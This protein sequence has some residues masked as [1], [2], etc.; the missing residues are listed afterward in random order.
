MEL[1]PDRSGVSHSAR[2]ASYGEISTALA[3]I[4]DRQLTR[5]VQDAPLIG[6]GIGGRAVLVHVRNTPVFVKRVP[7]TDLERRPENVMSTANIFGLPTFYHYGV[8]SAGSGAWRE[9]AA[10]VMT[11]NWVIGKQCE[12]F[13][14]MYHWRVLA[15]PPQRPPTPEEQA[16]LA[17]RV[18]YWH[19]SSAV[20]RRLEEIARSS[21][22][23]VLFCEYI[24]QNLYEW[25]NAQAARGD[26]AVELACAMVE[27]ALRTG[28]SF[29]NSNGLLH[30]DAHL[31]NI[32]TDGRRLYFTD[33]GLATS[34]RFELSAAESDFCEKNMSHDGCYTVTRLVNWLVSTLTGTV[35][36]V[37]RNSLMRRYAEGAEPVEILPSAAA[38]IRRYAP[39][40]VVMNDFYVKLHTESRATPYPVD[41]IRRACAA[42]GFEPVPPTS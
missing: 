6:S 9:L 37:D 12:S 16:N 19:G 41:E 2:I 29:M 3:L 8:S 18:A 32:L 17:R 31:R 23:L 34:P 4:G 14:L 20:R 33:F 36:P 13:P 42:I 26:G 1:P 22:S 28:V 27:Q 25:L 11:T 39:V 35:D 30:L 7:L 40:A 24:P 21:A 15:E 5:L 10:H 38:V